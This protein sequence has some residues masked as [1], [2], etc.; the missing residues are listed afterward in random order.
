MNIHHPKEFQQSFKIGKM[1]DVETT[2]LRRIQKEMIKTIY[3]YSETFSTVALKMLERK[4]KSFHFLPCEL[5][6]IVDEI[7]LLFTSAKQGKS[8]RWS[9]IIV[10]IAIMEKDMKVIEIQ[11]R[12][13]FHRITVYK[14][15]EKLKQAGFVKKGENGC[16]TLNENCCPILHWLT[17]GKHPIIVLPRMDIQKFS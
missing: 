8:F 11:E 2:L 9:I 16:W 13:G 17:R 3:E 6:N 7:R 14:A 12:T 5:S 4:L 15:L 1:F 10:G